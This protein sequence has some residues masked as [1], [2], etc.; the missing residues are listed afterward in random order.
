MRPARI[1]L[2]VLWTG[3]AALAVQLDGCAP[4]GTVG[5]LED[6]IKHD[7]AAQEYF[8]IER[9]MPGAQV[10]LDL[11]DGTQV[12][13][14][15]V[16]LVATPAADYARRYDEQRSADSLAALPALHS[17]VTLVTRSGKRTEGTLGGFGF[18][19]VVLERGG[20]GKTTAREFR[21][22]A[23]L[24]GADG[25]TFRADTLTMRLV[26]GE[27]P[28]M[29]AMQVRADDTA[30]TDVPLERIS[31]VAY[32]PAKGRVIVGVVLAATF[33]AVV[34]IA[35]A[36]QPKP[37]PRT[38]DCNNSGG[39]YTFDPALLREAERRALEAAP[40]AAEAAAR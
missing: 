30:T 20:A 5:R 12:R 10:T 1:R 17:A 19:R 25:R 40:V 6:P 21:D 36:N 7:L 27:V 3:S 31:S 14:R 32:K 9:L 39:V 13:G 33:V 26:R 37:R 2:A 8:M 4:I 28:V 18:G 24:E 15:F 11:R 34:I 16:A 38:L 35:H 23:T 22:F 29:T